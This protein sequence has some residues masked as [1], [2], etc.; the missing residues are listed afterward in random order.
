MISTREIEGFLAEFEGRV[1]PAERAVS[2]AWW[3]LATT[4]S[5]EAKEELVRAGNEYNALFAD[6]EEFERVKSWHERRG[7]LES[8]LLRRQVEVLYLTFAG[9]Q[10]DEKTLRRIEELEAEAN[11]IYGNYRGRVDGRDVGENEIRE[12]LRSSDD[13]ALRREAWEAQKSVGR[14]VEGTVREL[15]RLRNR[16]ARQQG[17]PDH[18]HRS[19]VLQEIDPEELVALMSALEATTGRPFRELKAH[20]DESL[21]ERFGVEKVMPWHLWDPFFQEP[22]EGSGEEMDRYFADADLEALTRR[23]Y[24]AMDLDV[25]GV[26]ARSDLY[27]RSGKSQHAF[28]LRVGRDYPYDVRVLANLRPGEPDAYWANTMLHEFGHAV[29]DRHINPGLPYLLRTVAH[30]CV[31]EGIA[32]M[33]DSLTEDQGWL[34]SVAGVADPDAEGLAARRR[35]KGLVFARWAL[36]MF[37]FERELYADPE[38]EDLNGLWW[39]LVERFQLVERPPERDYPDWAAKIHVAIA[40]VYYHNYV[41]GH[42]IAAQLRRHLE[43]GVARGAFYESP[44]TGRYLIESLFGPG[45]RADWR[46]T[47]LHAT[48]EPLNPEHFV[49]SLLGDGAR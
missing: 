36:V 49:R 26:M 14:A 38:R 13:L 11:A 29:Y 17:Y 28:C 27:E 5:E 46:N 45:A 39:D 47:V 34:S 23:T 31:T 41:L 2:E 7:D 37:H 10:G 21:K 48:G 24:D 43:V 18:Y 16:L 6:R 3:S 30:T 4:G 32:I 33:M 19:L 25:R 22:P 1:V 8:P 15:A 40:P 42:L 44:V 12:I 9:R 35:A 20:I